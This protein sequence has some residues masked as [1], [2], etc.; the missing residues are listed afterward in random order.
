M[1]APFTI[2]NTFP[3]VYRAVRIEDVIHAPMR[4]FLLRL[5]LFLHIF[6]GAV[7]LVVF[8][9]RALAGTFLGGLV[10]F[11]VSFNPFIVWGFF[12]IAASFFYAFLF[13]EF[14]F[15]MSSRT[16]RIG[17]AG[18]RA[19]MFLHEGADV[20]FALDILQEQKSFSLF[21]AYASLNR[22]ILFRAAL[23]RLGIAPSEFA[24]FLSDTKD[25]LRDA[26]IHNGD[27][28]SRMAHAPG[29]SQEIYFGA[30]LLAVSL[31]DIDERMR[32][33]LF[34]RRIGR[35]E[36][37]GV[38]LWMQNSTMEIRE[39]NA[40]WSKKELG[41]TPGVAKDFGFG[42]TYTLD[43]YS[44]EIASNLE[45][46]ALASR[47]RSI[48]AI[49]SILSKSGEANVLLVGKEGIGKDTLLEGLATRIYRGLVPPALEYKRMVRLDIDSIIAAAKTKGL[50][51]E[52]MA[53][54]LHEAMGAGNI[55]LVIDDLPHAIESASSIGSDFISIA[56]N[57]VSGASLQVVA[58]AD[59]YGY[60]KTL[61]PQG[62]I[63]S[64][65]SKID[66]EEPSEQEVVIILEEVVAELERKSRAIFSYQSLVRISE[67]AS[68][69]IQT[70]AMPE[71]AIN[72]ADEVY[73]SV[74]GKKEIISSEDVDMF[75]SQKLRIPF[76]EAK[77]E[78]KDTLL[79]LEDLLHERVINQKEA[80]HTIADTMRRARAGIRNQKRPIGSFLFLGPTGVGKTESAKALASVYFRGEDRMIRFD[81][82]EFQGE[83]GIKK[84]LGSFGSSEPGML[85]SAARDNPFALY[86]FDEIE[87]ASREVLNLFLQIL[88]EGFFS[89]AKGDRISM[90]ETIMIATSNAGASRM[91]ELVRAGKDPSEVKKEVVDVIQ[92]EGIISPELL[93]RF[94][95][96]V[97]FHSLSQEQLGEVAR[98]LL[99]ELKGRLA[100][101][102]IG[103]EISDEL[104]AR[105]V[106]IG[107]DPTFG[108]RPMRRAIADR[109]ESYLAK[110]MLSGELKRGDTA[111]FSE[112]EVKNL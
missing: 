60:H 76:G 68:R 48:D 40:L 99:E 112:E 84:M 78:E 2:A 15:I 110:K 46:L 29:D 20:F 62:K 43:M 16:V 61:E 33:F 83:E 28:L 56:E 66:I 39:R 89:D 105:V 98:L 7:L 8:A 91:W 3:S 87:K 47:K 23:V 1:S 75:A 51:E 88:E 41:R 82:S 22:N 9:L 32:E 71:K 103:L 109:V 6:S 86:L 90:R 36:F 58:L 107:F 19:I 4:R 108:A 34:K 74:S 102:D 18:E 25:I 77:S 81:M 44:H 38:L 100:E 67:I 55:I 93:N 94:D 5:G 26:R 64:L 69:F 31:Y 65:F 96:I 59:P 35:E 79:G 97:I 14:F 54:V 13:L 57:A 27:I 21:D 53:R 95:G 63:Q 45:A 101:K 52:Q 49:E 92:R 17:S 42:Y 80:I 70:G 72:L 10:S 12:F 111:R 106:E 24:G 73:A 50:F 104:I 37:E 11:F 30:A 85:A